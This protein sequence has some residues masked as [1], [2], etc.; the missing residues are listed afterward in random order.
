MVL[1]KSCH[2]HA[3]KKDNCFSKLQFLYKNLFHVTMRQKI[4]T[5]TRKLKTRRNKCYRNKKAVVCI[6]SAINRV[7]NI[8]YC[9]SQFFGVHEVRSLIRW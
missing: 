2:T 9:D 5:V 3:K 6:Q 8:C 4:V 1:R 7:P